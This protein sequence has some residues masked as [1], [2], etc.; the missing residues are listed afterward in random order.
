MEPGDVVLGAA[1]TLDG[2]HY[3]TKG[4]AWSL[5]GLAVV[6]FIPAWYV[7]VRS[8]CKAELLEYSIASLRPLLI[9][10]VAIAPAYFLTQPMPNVYLHISVAILISAPLCLGLSFILNREW[11]MAMMQLALPGRASKNDVD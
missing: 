7:L 5:L 1:G 10:V 6:K 8:L 11:L 2:T 3:G 9:A 4:L